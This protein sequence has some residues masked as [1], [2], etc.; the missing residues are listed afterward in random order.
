MTKKMFSVLSLAV[1]TIFLTAAPSLA[2]PITIDAT[3]NILDDY[4]MP[5][6]SFEVEIFASEGGDYGDIF[7]FGFIADPNQT[8]SFVS[9]DSY[10]IGDH[11]DDMGAGNYVSGF[12]NFD[13]TST[14][15]ILLATLSFTA[16]GTL[17]TDTLNIEGMFNWSQGT[18]LFY[19]C[20]DADIVGS[21]ELAVV[22]EP[23]TFAL[24]GIGIL[25]VGIWSKRRKD[26]N[27][28]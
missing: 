28:A 22:P 23:A 10:V 27:P 1:L 6:E 8:L 26:S 25:G 21:V 17:G 4:I 16:G 5:G 18:G 15:P 14:E 13:P 24:L 12:R 11:F 9:F 3:F 7:S 20:I 2:N 19:D